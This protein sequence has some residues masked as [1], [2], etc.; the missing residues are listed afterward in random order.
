MHPLELL[1]SF[2]LRRKLSILEEGRSFGGQIDTSRSCDESVS[3]LCPFIYAK[4]T[5]R[6]KVPII[7]LHGHLRLC[8]FL[9]ADKRCSWQRLSEVAGGLDSRTCTHSVMAHDRPG[10]S[11]DYL[12]TLT[13]PLILYPGHLLRPTWR[14]SGSIHC[15]KL[16]PSFWSSSRFDRQDAAST[17]C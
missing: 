4:L 3:I 6:S 2:F 17:P 8:R 9:S 10:L 15:P 5:G 1:A 16:K 12:H 13:S 14:N 11:H 7:S